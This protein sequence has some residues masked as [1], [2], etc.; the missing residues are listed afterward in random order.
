VDDPVEEDIVYSKDPRD[1]LPDSLEYLY[2]DVYTEDEWREMVKIFE[3]TNA[4][5]PKLTLENTCIDQRESTKYG[6]AVEPHIRFANPLF[7][8]IWRGHSYFL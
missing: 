5:T 2:L 6:R 8:D 1:N 3:T 7:D 4:N